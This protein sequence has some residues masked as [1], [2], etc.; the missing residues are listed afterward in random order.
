MATP[1]AV[2]VSARGEAAGAP[3]DSQAYTSGDADDSALQFS[4]AAAA[5]KSAKRTCIKQRVLS[6]VFAHACSCMDECGSEPKQPTGTGMT[7][8]SAPGSPR[9]LD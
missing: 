1:A 8:S 6:I 4:S 7:V 9:P 2:A 3:D 5:H